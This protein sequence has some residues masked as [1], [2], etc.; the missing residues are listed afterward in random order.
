M[1]EKTITIK[2]LEFVVGRYA[3]G[4]RDLSETEA[5]ELRDDIKG[6]GVIVPVI[7][8][9][10]R[11][12]ID[13]Q[14]RLAYAAELGVEARFE[15]RPGLTEEQKE[16]LAW[17]LNA[18]R[19]H[20][21]REERR[22]RAV[23]LVKAGATQAEAAAQL[24]VDRS[25]VSRD[26]QDVQL[27]KTER[28]KEK[29]AEL[30]EEGLSVRKIAAEVGASIGTVHNDIKAIAPPVVAESLADLK[31]K[32]KDFEAPGYI[33]ALRETGSEA[34]AKE[35]LK[36]QQRDERVAEV[37]SS[38]PDPAAAISDLNALVES[39]RSGEREPFSCIYADPPWRYG[40]QG[41]RG[42]TDNHYTTMTVEE[43][44]ALPVSEMVAEQAHLHLWVTSVFLPDA[45]DL[46][47]S[48]GFEYKSYL[49]WDKPQFGLGNYW[50]GPCELL[51]LG[52]RGQLQFLDHSIKAILREDRTRHS[53]KPDAFRQLIERVS[54]GPRLEM[55]ARRATPGWT[56]WGNEIEPG[57]FVVEAQG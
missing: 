4:L 8:D 52:V 7:V 26:V 11:A 46:M 34:K 47:R 53:A 56:A 19:R 16:A 49:V 14:H 35:R 44:S 57:L 15:I 3:R 17:D 38:A 2:G 33:E 54:P 36:K 5:Q 50:R 37:R 25:T 31:R 1:E 13:G 41:T 43:I 10:A 24:G 30:R 32:E 18:K 22:Q 40:N 45:F 55:F 9:E 20:L 6:R 51:L 21:T 23:E 29:V 48:W 39:I 42:A 27:H 28:R 12:V